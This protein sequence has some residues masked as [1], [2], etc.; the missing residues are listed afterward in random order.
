MSPKPA[1]EADRFIR[2]PACGGYFDVRDLQVIERAGPPP[3]PVGD[4]LR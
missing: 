4:Q 3:H 2:R 1:S